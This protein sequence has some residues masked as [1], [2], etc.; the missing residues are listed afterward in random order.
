MRES[1]PYLSPEALEPDMMHKG[2]FKP[3]VGRKINVMAMGELL[4][5][6]VLDITTS[7][8]SVTAKVL[9][10]P[11]QRGST[12]RKGQEIFA[13][14]DMNPLLHVE[15]WRMQDDYEIRAAEEAARFAREEEARAQAE[16]RARIAE[17]QRQRA[18]EEE[19][20]KRALEP[21]PIPE[22]P[23]YRRPV[24]GPRRTRVKKGEG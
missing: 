16:E 23:A 3:E 17:L 19:A 2:R 21:E 5:C 11:V 22:P 10:Q 18:A 20:K 15:E 24:L 1:R 14:R 13:V 8:N 12:I 9:V 6:E 4:L 7:K